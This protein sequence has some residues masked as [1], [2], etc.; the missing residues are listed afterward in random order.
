MD[1]TTGKIIVRKEMSFE[2]H[3]HPLL[4]SSPNGRATRWPPLFS[5]L[6]NRYRTTIT[7]IATSFKMPRCF[8]RIPLLSTM[9]GEILYVRTL[10]TKIFICTFKCP[11]TVL[12]R[13]I[14]KKKAR[15]N[16]KEQRSNEGL[17]SQS[18]IPDLY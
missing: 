2:S 5:Y 8:R 7:D 10:R 14:K 9:N 15:A 12:Y 13:A 16:L 3:L 17:T 4:P 18:L 6:L 11:F 1:M